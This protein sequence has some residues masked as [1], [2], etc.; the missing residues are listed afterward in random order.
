MPPQ[1]S[2]A[3][4]SIP[5]IL[6]LI[7]RGSAFFHVVQAIVHYMVFWSLSQLTQ[8]RETWAGDVGGDRRTWLEQQA[9]TGFGSTGSSDVAEIVDGEY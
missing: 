8:S 1:T 2:L 5:P 6:A 7:W 9:I 4:F 3:R